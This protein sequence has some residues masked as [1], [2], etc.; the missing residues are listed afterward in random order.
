MIW[1][2]KSEEVEE[3]NLDFSFNE[4]MQNEFFSIMMFPS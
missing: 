3:R 1:D 4:R 2:G